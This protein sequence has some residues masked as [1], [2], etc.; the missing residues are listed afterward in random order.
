MGKPVVHNFIFLDN[1]KTEPEKAMFPKDLSDILPDIKYPKGI[2]SLA[3]RLSPATSIA[4]AL[5]DIAGE[6]ENK[7][8]VEVSLIA[9]SQNL[10]IGKIGFNAS[11]K[12]PTLSEITRFSMGYAQSDVGKVLDGLWLT[13]AKKY[14]ISTEIPYGYRKGYCDPRFI[15]TV[16]AHESFKHIDIFNMNLYYE[17]DGEYYQITNIRKKSSVIGM[18]CRIKSIKISLPKIN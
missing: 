6:R 13:H 14:H 17:P 11:E 2:T 1:E 9:S 16:A 12:Y 15:D 8:P 18:E 7:R 3:G 4:W 5:A 10:T